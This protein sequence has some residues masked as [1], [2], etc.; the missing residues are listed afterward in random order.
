MYLRNAPVIFKKDGA[1]R[2]V[3]HSVK[4]EELKKLG[5]SQVE[6]EGEG[7]KNNKNQIDLSEV[8]TFIEEATNLLTAEE[9]PAKASD[10]DGV[11]LY[12]FRYEE[13]LDTEDMNPE[14]LEALEP[15][16]SEDKPAPRRRRKTEKKEDE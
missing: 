4:A 1:T 15:V 2:L 9:E 8:E 10:L 14:P 7:L 11:G 3:Y 5:W 16:M 13:D 12:E 6:E